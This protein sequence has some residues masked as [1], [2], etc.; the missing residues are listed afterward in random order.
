MPALPL[1]DIVLILVVTLCWAFNLVVLK[2]TIQNISPLS[3][4]AVRFL[5]VAFPLVF[6][7]KRPKVPISKLFLI[8]LIL[9]VAKFALLFLGIQ[10]GISVGVCALTLQTQVIFTAIISYIFFGARLLK[11]EIA[12]IF[13]AL[14]GVAMLGI[15]AL[16]GS[17]TVGFILVLLSALSWG[18]SNN[19]SRTFK[20]VNMLQL[21]VWMSLIPPIPYFLLS[22]AL[23]GPNVFFDSLKNFG[24]FELLST[25]YIVFAA[26]LFGLTGWTWLMRQ[27]N[28]EK[29]SIYGLLIPVFSLFFGWL[30]LD[31][32]LTYLDMI[33]CV[34]VF[35]GLIINQWP[36]S[37]VKQTQLIYNPIKE[38]A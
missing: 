20:G 22:Q 21:T 31:E 32:H 33:A 17:T 38:V 10:R 26:T 34:V 13:V 4:G 27:H 35:S 5:F 30:C 7:I 2:F 16:S 9:G 14:C 15:Q 24:L 36:N 37:Q 23:E 3:L 19:I 25:S 28:P 12:G 8:G 1:K 18:I 11:R 29:V 6:F